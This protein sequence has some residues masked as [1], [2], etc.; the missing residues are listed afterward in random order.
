MGTMRDWLCST[1]RRTNRGQS[2]GQDTTLDQLFPSVIWGLESSMSKQG[3]RW[4]R[5]ESISM[6]SQSSPSIQWWGNDFKWRVA[7][8]GWLRDSAK[9]STSPIPGAQQQSD[10]CRTISW[11][12][13]LLGKRWEDQHQSHGVME[14]LCDEAPLGAPSTPQSLTLWQKYCQC[15]RGEE[16]RG[17]TQEP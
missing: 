1:S 14:K 9:N 2:C 5:N 16:G 12:P 11:I 4:L 13:M 17:K 15:C 10:I 3:C 8:N 7:V 6:W